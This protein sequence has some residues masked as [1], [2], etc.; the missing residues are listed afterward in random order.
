MQQKVEK[1][2]SNKK[3]LSKSQ[4]ESNLK[5]SRKPVFGQTQK[6]IQKKNYSLLMLL[7]LVLNSK[8]SNS[9]VFRHKFLLW[10]LNFNRFFSS[11]LGRIL[12]Q[13]KMLGLFFENAKYMQ[14]CHIWNL[15]IYFSIKLLQ[16]LHMLGVWILE[17][18]KICIDKHIFLSFSFNFLVYQHLTSF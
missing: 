5:W 6:S 18:C 16:C 10:F 9:T 7:F 12:E 15:I 13:F 11:F 1:L 2:K 4:Q 3:V 17:K 14:W 8:H